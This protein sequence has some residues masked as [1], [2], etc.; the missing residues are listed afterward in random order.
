MSGVALETQVRHSWGRHRATLSLGG[1]GQVAEGPE[2]PLGVLQ[3]VMEVSCPTIAL[4]VAG[5]HTDPQPTYILKVGGF[6]C[7]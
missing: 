7:I 4:V 1:K 2:G 5:L 3:G 6:H